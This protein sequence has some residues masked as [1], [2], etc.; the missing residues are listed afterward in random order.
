MKFLSV[1]KLQKTTREFFNEILSC[2]YQFFCRKVVLFYEE[3]EE[4]NESFK[5]KVYAKFS[6]SWQQL[7]HNLDFFLSILDI[8]TNF[9]QIPI[10]VPICTKYLLQF[11]E[12]FRP[13]YRCTKTQDFHENARVAKRCSKTPYWWFSDESRCAKSILKSILKTSC[14]PQKC[15][16]LCLKRIINIPETHKDVPRTYH[17]WATLLVLSLYIKAILRNE[18]FPPHFNLNK[19]HQTI[20]SS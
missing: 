14:N 10:I 19:F 12:T 9:Q 15:Y 2:Y 5:M 7:C 3:S 16:I 6:R 17:I 13:S 11:W 8:S 4:C 1:L 20:F 18:T